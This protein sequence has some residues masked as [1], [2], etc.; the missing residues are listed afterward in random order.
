[1]FVTRAANNRGFLCVLD[2]GKH[3]AVALPLGCPAL[4]LHVMLS[5]TVWPPLLMRV[6]VSEKNF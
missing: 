6:Q 3:A 2:R 1:M 4:S 5:S